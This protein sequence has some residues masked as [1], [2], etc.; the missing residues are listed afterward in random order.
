MKKELIK[1]SIT[2]QFFIQCIKKKKKKKVKKEENLS[3]VIVA[4][5]SLNVVGLINWN[6]IETLQNTKQQKTVFLHSIYKGQS[7]VILLSPGFLT[8]KL[9]NN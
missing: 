9:D 1:V 7:P 6:Y 8:Q 3:W 2:L 4:M 5:W